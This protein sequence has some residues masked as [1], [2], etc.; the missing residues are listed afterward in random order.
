MGQIILWPVKIKM[1]V[2]LWLLKTGTILIQMSLHNI[3]FIAVK[4]LGSFKRWVGT[5]RENY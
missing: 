5:Y 4:H 1:N 3:K 2:F